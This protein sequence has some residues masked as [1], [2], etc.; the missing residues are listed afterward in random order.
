VTADGKRA[1]TTSLNISAPV[2]RAVAPPAHGPDDGGLR[3]ARTM[4][5]VRS[6]PTAATRHGPAPLRELRH[7]CRFLHG[8]IRVRGIARSRRGQGLGHVQHR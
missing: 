4:S 8:P 3:V 2:R 7:G 1:L 6:R 5:A